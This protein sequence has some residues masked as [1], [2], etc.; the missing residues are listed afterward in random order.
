MSESAKKK[1]VETSSSTLDSKGKK[2]KKEM[3]TDGRKRKQQSLRLL[4]DSTFFFCHVREENYSANIHEFFF[5][6]VPNVMY[7]FG[8]S[9]RPSLKSAKMLS[10]IAELYIQSLVRRFSLS[11]SLCQQ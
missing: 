3:T 7:G 6:T 2:R 9:V 1:N 4:D 5:I 10:E 11:L 8:D